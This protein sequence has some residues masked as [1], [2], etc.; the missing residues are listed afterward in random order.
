M[1]AQDV[2]GMYLG[3]LPCLPHEGPLGY[4]SQGRAGNITRAAGTE[5]CDWLPGVGGTEDGRVHSADRRV[6][7]D[8]VLGS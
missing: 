8:R 5:S 7:Y 2:G 4:S 6:G 3:T 1:G